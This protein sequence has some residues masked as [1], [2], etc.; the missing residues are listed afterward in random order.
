M[1]RGARGRVLG[2]RDVDSCGEA[3]RDR[4]CLLMFAHQILVRC[5]RSLPL[6]GEYPRLISERLFP[7]RSPTPASGARSHVPV[8]GLDGSMIVSHSPLAPRSSIIGNA[9]D[10]WNDC[11][12]FYRGLLWH[13]FVVR[14]GGESEWYRRPHQRMDALQIVL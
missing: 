7:T 14:A 6:V 9:V 10:L 8:T 4:G 13:R 5:T 3:V 1:G 2:L 11:V 12:Q